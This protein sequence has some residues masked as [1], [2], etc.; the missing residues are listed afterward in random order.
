MLAWYLCDFSGDP[1]SGPVLLRNPILL[2]IFRG[3]GGGW[4]GVGGS[5]P[6]VHPLDQPMNGIFEDYYM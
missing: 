4:G 1:D 6:P 5:G 2:C 3:G